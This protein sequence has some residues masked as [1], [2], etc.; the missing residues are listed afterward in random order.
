[1]G[2]LTLADFQTEILAATGDRD[3]NSTVSLVRIVR[4]LNMA[5]QHISRA[6]TFQELQLTALADMAYTANPLVDKFLVPPQGIRTLHSFVLVDTSSGFSSKGMSRKLVEKPWRW[7]DRMFPAPEWL[8]ASWPEIYTWWGSVL[9]MAPAPQAAYTAQLRYVANP[10]PFVTSDTTQ[11]SEYEQK[12]DIL[13]NLA[14]AYFW[15]SL[16]RADRSQYFMGLGQEQ[17]D[18]AIARDGEHPDME[19]SRD[20]D[21]GIGPVGDYWS[22]PWVNSVNGV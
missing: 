4:A 1:M 9:V 2:T 16:G 20:I 15:R 5:Q 19:V 10:E 11:V 17:L 14:I 22:N 18:E 7:F 12:D 13:L 3:E 21:G 8:P 6:H